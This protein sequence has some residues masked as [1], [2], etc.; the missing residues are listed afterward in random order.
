MAGGMRV[1]GRPGDSSEARRGRALPLIAGGGVGTLVLLAVFVLG[2][3]P[4]VPPRV[5]APART[6]ELPATSPAHDE[7]RDFV[8]LVLAETEDTWAELF[9]RMRREYHDPTL[10][11]FAGSV[12][13]ACGA[14]GA[15]V[16][17]FYCP[18]DR[19]LYLD[20]EFFGELRGRFG[21]PGDLAQAYV[22]AHEIG[23]HVQALL[24]IAEPAVSGTPRGDRAGARAPGVRQ[25]LQAD[26]F[27]G[28]WAHH[29]SRTRGVLTAG[30]LG[31]ALGAAAA[32]GEDRLQRLS[33]GRVALESFT[34]GTPAQRL[35]W[36]RRGF[37]SGAVDQCDT[38]R[39][40]KL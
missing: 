40:D 26:C 12:P 37:D 21:A 20:L 39:A 36:F 8:A 3:D 19:T 18:G 9:R 27:A 11:L 14:P 24:G 2:L 16:G 5:E 32:L 15:A 35:R 6:D 4:G 7:L 23:H 31:E 33:P 1:T 30:D 22:I 25:E 29:A 10:V 28:V 38:F 17:P 13:G 34:H